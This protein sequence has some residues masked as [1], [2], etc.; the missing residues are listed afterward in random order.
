MD[1]MVIPQ[2]EQDSKDQ[3]LNFL[4]M[5]EDGTMEVRRSA[6]TKRDL[7]EAPEITDPEL[8]KILNRARRNRGLA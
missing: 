4:T 5:N 3:R 7:E 6:L 8:L 1:E 2:K